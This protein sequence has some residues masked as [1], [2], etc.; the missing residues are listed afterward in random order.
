[1][2]QTRSITNLGAEHIER[3]IPGVGTLIF[4]N[5]DAGQWLT[6]KNEPAKKAKRIYS[7]NDVEFDAVSS[8][9]DCMDKYAL[10]AWYGRHGAAGATR[11]IRLGLIDADVDEGDVYDLLPSLDLGADVLKKEAADRGT[12]TH[13]GF[14]GLANGDGP[15]DPA[16]VP[17]HA[18]PWLL[19]SV[20]AWQALNPEPVEVEQI[21]CHPVDCYAGRPDLI[22]RIDGELCLLDWKTSK[23]GVYPEAFYQTRLYERAR[24]ACGF[25]PCERLLIVGVSDSGGFVVVE[26]D[27]TDAEA[28]AL[29]V[30]FR[31]RRRSEASIRAQM[32][33]AKKALAAAA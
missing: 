1:M 18:R 2:T 7:L 15:P 6:Q 21:V 27:V 30:V 9:V 33:A 5:A 31:S 3:V 8:V 14:E 13:A 28:E 20:R 25:E 32:S 24:R 26:S 23:G 12:I 10:R 16:E 4:E 19:G 29:L 11:A 17:E 22:A